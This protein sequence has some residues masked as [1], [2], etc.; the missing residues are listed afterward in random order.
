MNTEVW[1]LVQR[2]F[3]GAQALPVEERARWLRAEAAGEPVVALVMGML[4]T[5]DESRVDARLHPPEPDGTCL[6]GRLVGEFQL[7]CEIGRGAMGVVYRARQIPL[8]RFVAVK[9]LHR[10][11]LRLE[12]SIRFRREAQVAA[13]LDHAGIVKVITY[14]E[15]NDLLYFA[16]EIVE[17]WSLG[18][19][20]ESKKSERAVPA[21]APDLAVVDVVVAL[22]RDIVQ[23]L[24]YAHEKGVY[25]RDIKPLNVLIARDGAPKLADF[26]LALAVDL[27]SIT[28]PGAI[29]GTPR[30]MSP[31]QALAAR[32]TIDHRTDIYSLGVVL[33][34]LLASELP[35]DGETAEELYYKIAHTPPVHLRWR[36]PH[37]PIPLIDICMK[38]IRRRREERYEHATDLADDLDRFL[39]REPVVAAP[40]SVSSALRDRLESRRALVW[41][42]PGIALGATVGAGASFW[43]SRRRERLSWPHIHFDL[44]DAPAAVDVVARELSSADAR[45]A[46]ELGRSDAGTF[47]VRAP[48]A[49]GT[50][51]FELSD[52]AGRTAEVVRSV[53]GRE[54]VRALVRPSKPTPSAETLEGRER[55]A[56][57]VPTFLV[58]R[59]TVTNQEFEEY[60][61]F[62]LAR[63]EREAGA[64]DGASAS[65]DRNEV[66]RDRGEWLQLPATGVRWSDAC[67]F[68]EWRGMRLPRLDE[69]HGLLDRWSAAWQ[70]ALDGRR[71]VVGWPQLAHDDA[72]IESELHCPAPRR[73]IGDTGAAYRAFVKPARLAVHDDLGV[74]HPIGN[75]SEWLGS[76]T[77]ADSP[78]VGWQTWG[79]PWHLF[80]SLGRRSIRL[81]AGTIE[82]KTEFPYGYSASAGEGSADLGFRCAKSQ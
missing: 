48:L 1:E 18:E 76:P 28:R 82:L 23:A 42:L 46:L 43:R 64:A 26:G 73:S 14:G 65:I 32:K 35:Y 77:T 25:H 75:V 31:E 15:D 80:S 55:G 12:S 59:A 11:P 47:D 63:R 71:L 33:Y 39:N 3:H 53:V 61:T 36:A 56:T 34:E 62:V 38:A 6:E 57:G 51:I 79:G 68:A 2:L 24:A 30:Y 44:L 66:G 52:D 60:R 69:W 78:I 29:Q 5:L 49:S 58:D 19:L 27:A 13:R 16:M 74:F 40:Q 54:P 41:A 81:E 70:A 50:R 45:P 20:L 7:I 21:G 72:A 22:V 67:A 4:E 9:V 10:H 17:G 37:L 8:D